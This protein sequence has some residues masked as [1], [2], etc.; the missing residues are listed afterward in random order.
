MNVL[1]DLLRSPPLK[2]DCGTGHSK[3][4][5]M[6]TAF[7]YQEKKTYNDF[8]KNQRMASFGTNIAEK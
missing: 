3:R 7:V 2:N 8:S 1:C 5:V 4:L 6:F